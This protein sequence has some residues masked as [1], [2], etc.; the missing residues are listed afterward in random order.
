M[1]TRKQPVM[2]TIIGIDSAARGELNTKGTLR[3]DGT[4]EGKVRADWVIV[5]EPGTIR[6]DVICRGI[7]VGGKV[8]GT[9]HASE[10]VDIKGKGEIRGDIYAAKLAVSEGGVLEGHSYMNQTRE[11]DRTSV[12][13]FVTE[14]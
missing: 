5:G 9:I 12:L 8:E 13:P 1:L 7:I 4:A 14:R 6:G 3:V 10:L 2:E 11:S